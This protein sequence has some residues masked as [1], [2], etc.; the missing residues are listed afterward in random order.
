MQPIFA[1]REGNN[2]LAV[3][4]QINWVLVSILTEV[5][6]GILLRPFPSREEIVLVTGQEWRSITVFEHKSAPRRRAPTLGAPQWVKKG[7]DRPELQ[8]QCVQSNR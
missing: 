5:E 7:P 2:D 6:S 8:K 1:A 3:V 4:L